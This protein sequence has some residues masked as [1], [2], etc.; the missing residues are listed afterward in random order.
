MDLESYYLQYR[1][2]LNVL[3][4]LIVALVLGG[5]I[6]LEREMKKR[7]AGFRTHMLVA[8]A[9]AL[10]T[11]LAILLITDS[12]KHLDMSMHATD[13]VRVIVAITTGITFLGAGT[14]F[15]S[16]D[17]VSGLTTAATLLMASTLGIAVALE[18]YVVAA[19]T[20]V[21]VLIV[22]RTLGSVSHRVGEANGARK[23]DTSE[24]RRTS[25]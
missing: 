23:P 18:Q 2:Q 7:P 4:N 25:P 10:L 22:V 1:E 14:I 24:T 19:G 21:I 3:F 16:A 6:G 13:P 20:T 15:R 5:V 8:G 9:A 12:E 17:G 11:D